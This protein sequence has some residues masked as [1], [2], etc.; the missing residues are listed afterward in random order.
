MSRP[1]PAR[2]FDVFNPS[3]FNLYAYVG[4]NPVNA[5]DPSGLQQEKKKKYRVNLNALKDLIDKLTDKVVEEVAEAMPVIKENISETV[6]AGIRAYGLYKFYKSSGEAIKDVAVAAGAT[7]A[8][9]PSG[10]TTAPVI[11]TG[12]AGAAVETVSAVQGLHIAA[13]GKLQTN[14]FETLGA[15]AAIK[16]GFSKNSGRAVAN[17]LMGVT[18]ALNLNFTGAAANGA[19][20]VFYAGSVAVGDGKKTMG[21]QLDK[22]VEVFKDTEFHYTTSSGRELVF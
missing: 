11:A 14:A 1:D 15:M 8:A 16:L 20:T 7:A 18:R 6:D 9:V 19:S 2:D 13:T 4:N 12:L 17:G 5:W 21:E 22:A 10:G 3:S